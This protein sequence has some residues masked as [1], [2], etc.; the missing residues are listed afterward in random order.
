MVVIEQ[1]VFSKE[2]MF[3]MAVKEEERKCQGRA[4]RLAGVISSLERM[5]VMSLG[6]RTNL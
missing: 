1:H 3:T 5:W 6:H 2:N 4:G